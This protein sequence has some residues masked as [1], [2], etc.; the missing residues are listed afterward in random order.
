MKIWVVFL[1]L[2]FMF[3]ASFRE[4]DSKMDKIIRF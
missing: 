3:H 2:A 4:G 1:T